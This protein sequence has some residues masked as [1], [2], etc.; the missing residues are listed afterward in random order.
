MVPSAEYR[1]FVASVTGGTCMAAIS[2]ARVQAAYNSLRGAF[3]A[4]TY[5][6]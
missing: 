3:V 6:Q 5:P 2:E 4:A 1:T